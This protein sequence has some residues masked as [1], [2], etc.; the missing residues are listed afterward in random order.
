LA[1]IVYDAEI[2]LEATTAFPGTDT[3]TLPNKLPVAAPLNAPAVAPEAVGIEIFTV[4]LS[5]ALLHAE[6]AGA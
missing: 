1:L 5:V 4:P 3:H 2:V 6:V